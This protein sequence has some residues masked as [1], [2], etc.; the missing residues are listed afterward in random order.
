[1]NI[2]QHIQTLKSL[3][4]MEE[5][6]QEKKWFEKDTSLSADRT[7]R[8]AG[9]RGIKELRREGAIIHPLSLKNKQFGV[10]DQPISVFTFS[11]GVSQS[12][13]NEGTPISLF[14]VDNDEVVNGQILSLDSSQVEV[15]L[16]AD[17]FP[18]W[19]DEKNVGIKRL[20]DHRSF[21]A[22]HGVLK[23]IEEGR[24]KNTQ[25][26][27]EYIHGLKEIPEQPESTIP[28]IEVSNLNE[29]Q[30]EAIHSGLSD[31]PVQFFHGP[32]GTGKTTTLVALIEE[33]KKQDLKVI[34]SAPSNAAVD[35]LAE[36]LLEKDISI[37][38][39]GNTAK[40]NQDVWKHTPDGILSRDE[41]HKPLKKLKIKANEYRKLARQYKRSF[42]KEE[43][44]QRQKMYGEFKALKKEIKST[45]DYYISKYV[46]AADVVL[47]T[48]VGLMNSLIAD[49]DF[50]VAILDEAGQCIE[51]MAWLVLD[52]GNKA[53]LSGDHLQ[54]PPTVIDQKAAK[55]G[56]DK[57]ILERILSTQIP[58][59][60][61]QVQYRMT[62]EIAGFSSSYFYDNQL[63]SVN[64]SISDSFV[65]YDTAGA[66]FD[67]ERESNNSSYHNHSELNIISTHYEKWIQPYS[68]AV[69]ISPYANQVEK[70]KKELNNIQVS[71][72]DAFQGQEAELIILSLVRSNEN[73][74]IGFLSDY[75]R[76]NVALTRAQ[77]KLIVI[78]DSTTLTGDPFY[79]QFVQY[80][81][82][83]NAYHSIY[84]L[85]YEG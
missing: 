34:A 28:S 30:T 64:E 22:M 51:P 85:I 80:A 45:T 74:N 44:E 49:I 55:G 32:P 39:L 25:L 59:H 58:R 79:D 35:H 50:D 54:L 33:Y 76:M 18:T 11:H 42:G 31:V 5:E 7:Y 23:S 72:I 43:R 52:R 41:F 38:R 14:C 16:Y 27:F 36:K 6:N 61:L 81:D 2:I 78:G 21:K 3:L 48:P 56:L 73:R 83:I 47:G 68:S 37:V 53:I 62:P 60:L 26:L 67:E 46:D 84:E 20:P 70:A 63:Q 8:Q 12:V 4:R 9:R 75:R 15:L 82:K 69:F 24:N 71:T 65:F 10:T 29:Y 19:I 40:V 13:F 66:D 17:D 77:K 1:M 57:S